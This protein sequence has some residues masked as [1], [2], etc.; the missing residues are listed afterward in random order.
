[1]P[2]FGPDFE[3]AR[4]GVQ[5]QLAALFT[6]PEP[7]D[8][9][10]LGKRAQRIVRSRRCWIIV[11]EMRGRDRVRR[12]DTLDPLLKHDCCGR[13]GRSRPPPQ[14]CMPGTMQQPH[15]LAKLVQF[16]VRCTSASE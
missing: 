7:R 16:T 12:H 6:S 13:T 2:P 10:L 9:G 5:A 1:M 11:D 3:Q 4:L 14:W 15:V 8:T